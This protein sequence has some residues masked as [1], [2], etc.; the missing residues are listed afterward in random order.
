[1]SNAS[2]MKEHSAREVQKLIGNKYDLYWAAV[3]NGFYLPKL[4]SSIL[5]EEYIEDV[6][7]RRVLCPMYSEIRLK[8]CPAPPDKETLIRH[9]K[10]Y[11]RSKNKSTGIDDT[12]I[13]DKKWLLDFLSTYSPDCEI[14]HKS[15]VAPPRVVAAQDETKVSLPADFMK[16]LPAPRRKA[17]S[18]RLQMITK[19]K[20]EGRLD[21]MKQMQEKFKKEYLKEKNRLDARKHE[22]DKKRHARQQRQ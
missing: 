5:T 18:K 9:V 19:Q 7:H 12:H 11:A 22:A 20:S 6:I 1:M 21:R 2:A 16:D 4:K 15:Y 10:T 13:P 8:P 3:R 17:K 14:F